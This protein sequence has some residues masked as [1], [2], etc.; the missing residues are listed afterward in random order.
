MEESK[1]GKYELRG[2]LG[3]GAMGTVYEGW[4]PMISRKVAIKTVRLPDAADPEAQEELARFKRE[5]QAAGRLNHPNIVGVFDYGETAELAY[6]VMEFIDGQSLKGVLDK[7]ERF[8]PTEIVRV[9]E[10]LL[11]GLQFSHERGVV[12]RDIKPAN[13]MIT[14]GGQVK[15]ADFGIARIESSSMTQAG[16]VLGTPAYMSPEQF[17]GQTVDARTDIYSSGVLLYQLLTGERPF[18]GSMSAIMHKALNTEPPRPSD[19]SVTAPSAL[20]AVVAKA[21]AKRPEQR[22]ADAE[23][24]ARALRAAFEQPASTASADD[25][26]ATMVRPTGVQQTG[27]APAPASPPARPAAPA[28]PGGSRL[29]L[30]AGGGVIGL[31][32]LGGVGWYLLQPGTMPEQQVQATPPAVPAPPAPPPAPPAPTPAPQPAPVPTPTQVPAPQPTPTPTPAPAPPPAPAPAPIPVPSPP[33]PSPPAPPP[34][35]QP[36]PAPAPVPP[37]P[38]Q[39]VPPPPVPPA[40]VQ[41]F[42]LASLRAAVRNVACTIATPHLPDPGRILLDG[43]SG[44]GAPEA[45]LRRAIA[46]AAPATA[47]TWR[48]KTFD[49]PYCPALDV[50]RPIADNDGHPGATLA[51]ALKGNVSRLHR[52]DKIVLQFTMPD[53]PAYL[54]VDYLSSDGS[55]THLVADDGASVRVMTGNGWKVMGPSRVYRPGA[56][57]VIGEPDPKTGDGSWAVDEPFGTDMIVAIASSAPLFSTVR[58]ADDTG[59]TYFRDLKAALEQAQARGVRLAGQAM[60]LETAAK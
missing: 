55:M 11:A 48:V 37:A 54:Q 33:V 8:A 20:D 19:L 41:Q 12:H 2:T 24:F 44:G 43:L 32:L 39:P 9:M 10:Q 29:P 50:L 52:N 60:L 28:T 57:A 7:Q 6:I 25:T 4:D 46:E 53:F 26:D 35:P 17:M 13:V 49:G 42:S 14:S 59:A 47:L 15:I 1:L 51:L 16:T 27:P 30:I 3:R 56:S 34:M 58:P 5:A 45:A 18:E 23:A 22:Y 38:L 40:P 31:A 21:M 36:V